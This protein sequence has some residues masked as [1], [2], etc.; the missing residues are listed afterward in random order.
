MQHFLILSIVFPRKHK[1]NSHQEKPK[2]WTNYV[3][4]I[5]SSVE[6]NINQHRLKQPL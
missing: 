1:L 6:S 3:S 5:V 4:L 2:V